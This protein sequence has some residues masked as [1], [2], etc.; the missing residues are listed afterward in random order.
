MPHALKWLG[1]YIFIKTQGNAKKQ[2]TPIL[3][4]KLLRKP[5]LRMNPAVEFTILIGHRALVLPMVID[6][7]QEPKLLYSDIVKL[8][9][10]EGNKQ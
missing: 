4:H 3:K 5:L 6:R 8:K 7:Y 9:A 2:D 1:S 10:A